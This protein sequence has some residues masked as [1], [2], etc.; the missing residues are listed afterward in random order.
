MFEEVYYK[1]LNENYIGKGQRILPYAVRCKD[2]KELEEFI[3][4]LT[5][6]CFLCAEQIEGQKALLVN[7]EL[8][9]WCT[10]PK[11]C[12]MSCIDG[13]IYTVEEF[14]KLYYSVRKFPYT[15]EIL[16]HYRQDFLKALLNIKDKGKPFLTKEQAENIVD[17][18]CDE[19]LAYDMQHHTPEELAEINTM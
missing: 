14:K 2:E 5:D 16:E 1:E 10:F 17:S 3:K 4:Y 9:R 6:K 7:L 12:A 8:K 19:D 13:K 18:Y 15:S 11:A